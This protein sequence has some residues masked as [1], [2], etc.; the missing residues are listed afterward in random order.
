MAFHAAN[1]F[2]EDPEARLARLQEAARS[3]GLELPQKSFE[4]EAWELGDWMVI[5]QR[6]NNV[7]TGDAEHTDGKVDSHSPND[8]GGPS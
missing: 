7:G 4:R 6:R 5:Q 8:G 1:P 2:A 3:L